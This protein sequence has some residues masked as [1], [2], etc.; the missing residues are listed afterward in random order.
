MKIFVAINHT[1]SVSLP[2]ENTYV[3]LQNFKISLKAP[4]II[5]TDFESISKSATGNKNDGSSTEKYQYHTFYSL[6]YKL[7]CVGEQYSRSYTTYFGE[8]ANDKLI[9]DITNE[10]DYCRT[11]SA[12]KFNKPYK[13]YSLNKSLKEL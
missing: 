1:K 12:R 2:E 9:I 13:N 3:R 10:N 11:S 7:I 4:F 5:H 8:E 6:G